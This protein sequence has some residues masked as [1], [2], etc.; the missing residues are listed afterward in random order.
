[1]EVV[2]TPV[3]RTLPCVWKW[4]RLEN[5]RPEFWGSLSLK[6]LVQKLPI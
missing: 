6:R 3:Q 5:A 2:K 1:M 4:A